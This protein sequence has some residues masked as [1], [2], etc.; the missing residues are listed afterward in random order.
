[1]RF[2]AWKVELLLD[3]HVIQ[4]LPRNLA[5]EVI[6][7]SEEGAHP[8]RFMSRRFHFYG[9]KNLENALVGGVGQRGESL[10]EPSGTCEQ[11]N[12]GNPLAHV[13]TFPSA[14]KIAASLENARNQY[15]DYSVFLS[16]K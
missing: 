13:V 1:M 8:K 11:V 6:D 5:L 9:H 16:G 3:F 7:L 12:D 15:F 4:I 14:S 10:S 2:A